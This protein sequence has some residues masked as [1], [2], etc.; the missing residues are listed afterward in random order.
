MSSIELRP[1]RQDQLEDLCALSN[2]AVS[3]EGLPR[4]IT[5][6]EFEETIA[7]PYLDLDLDARA[8]YVDGRLVGWTWVWNPPSV[9]LLERAYLFGDVDPVARGQGVGH[10]LLGWGVARAE[11]RLRSRDHHLPRYVRVEAYEWMEANH[12]VYADFGFTPTRWFE[13]LVRPLRHLPAVEPVDGVAFVSWPADQDEVLRAVRNAAFA[14]H[15][16]SAPVDP[17]GWQATVR[18]HGARLDLSVIAIEEATGEPVALCLNHAYPEDD[19][20]TGRREAWIENLGTLGAWRGRGLASGML[21]WSMRAFADAGFSHAMI[22]VDS[23]N[24]TGAARLYRN[25]GFERE[26]RSITHH[27]EITV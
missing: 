2:R 11:E 22:A 12:R 17:A 14:D 3:H 26:R 25:L 9:H 19:E 16:G 4:V 13:E 5:V 10:S 24:P 21:A 6:E 7:A 1:V 23:D 20:R 8:A 27:L 15:W 18:G